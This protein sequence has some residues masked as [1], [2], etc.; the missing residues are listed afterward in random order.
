[1]LPISPT[2]TLLSTVAYA[3]LTVA[4]ALLW[5]RTRSLP[6]ALVTIGFALVLPDQLIEQAEYF[7]FITLLHGRPPDTYFLVY[8]HAVLRCVSILGLWVAAVGLVWHASRKS[9][10]PGVS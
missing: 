2:L 4:G 5:K 6:T 1:M 3:V 7:Q 8:H 9:A 10:P